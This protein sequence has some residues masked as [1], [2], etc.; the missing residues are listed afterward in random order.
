MLLPLARLGLLVG[1]GAS[2]RCFSNESRGVLKFFDS[3]EG[4]LGWCGSHDFF[5]IFSKKVLT[6]LS[7]AV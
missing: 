6:G 1:M 3:V 4:V 5:V 2:I 7:G